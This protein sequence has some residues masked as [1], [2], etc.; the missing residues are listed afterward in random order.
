MNLRGYAICALGASLLSISFMVG[1]GDDHGGLLPK[2]LFTIGDADV[3]AYTVDAKTGAITIVTGSPF[4][5]GFSAGICPDLA[6]ADPKGMLLF[7]P[8]ACNS[9][10]AAFTI[11]SKTGGLTPVTGSPFAAGTIS[12]N[13]EQPVVDPSAKFLYVPEDGGHIL[14]FNIGPGGALTAITG[15]PFAAGG[16]NETVVVHPNGKFLYAADGNN[17]GNVPG[18]SI[19]GFSIDAT[20]GALTAVTG[21]PFALADVPKFLAIDRTGKYLYVT[22][23]ESDT[24]LAFS[25]DTSTGALT[26][27]TGSPFASGGLN[28][29]DIAV[30]PDGK[31]VFVANNGDVD[32]ATNGSVSAFAL[33]ASTGALTAVAGSPFTAGPNPKRL[34][35]DPSGKYLYATNED[36]D[37]MSAFSIN[38]GSGVL[39]AIT[40]SPFATNVGSEGVTVTR[41]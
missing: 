27:L 11:D 24:V 35:V 40:G 23:P 1:C 2:F 17:V 4:T 26:Q 6:A 19:S 12:F 10:I 7:V 15:S 16:N 8:D 30:S 21:S 5:S 22:A 37:N 29:Q 32:T 33:N 41:K 9:N 18:P 34:A 25:I 38:A 14:G 31:F 28:P 36:S 39:T 13:V 3:G 20:S